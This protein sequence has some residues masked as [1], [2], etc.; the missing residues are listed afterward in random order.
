M[1]TCSGGGNGTVTLPSL[2]LSNGIINS[3]Q[4]SVVRMATIPIGVTSWDKNDLESKIMGENMG[5]PTPFWS[6]QARK[7]YTRDLLQLEQCV[8]SVAEVITSHGELTS[9]SG[10]VRGST[11]SHPNGRPLNSHSA[12]R[13]MVS[14]VISWSHGGGLISHGLLSVSMTD[15]PINMTGGLIHSWNAKRPILASKRKNERLKMPNHTA[16]QR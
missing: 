11:A 3:W 10:A 7:E 14:A 1:V 5:V 2:N 8:P 16:S 9:E 13:L 6:D 4:P 12:M 15:L